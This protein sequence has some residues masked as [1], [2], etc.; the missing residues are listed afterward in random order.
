MIGW[1]QLERLWSNLIGLGARRL[2]AL[3]IIG[4][5]VFA[6]VG[7]AGYYLSRPEFETL[8]SGLSPQDVGRI[9]ATLREFG[10]PFDVNAQGTAVLVHIGQTA[11]AR[12][13]LAEK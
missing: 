8:Y 13:L 10:I 11:Q 9:G 6:G 4:S 1:E 2:V 3:G 5:L 12:M 7:L